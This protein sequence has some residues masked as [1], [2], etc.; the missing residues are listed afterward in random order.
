M[1]RLAQT[2]ASVAQATIDRLRTE[3]DELRKDERTLVEEGAK[4]DGWS[5][6]RVGLSEDGFGA[7]RAEVGTT[8]GQEAEPACQTVEGNADCTVAELSPATPTL[9]AGE[10]GDDAS[11]P[12]L[13]VQKAVKHVH[14]WE[15]PP[16]V[17]PDKNGRPVLGADG[18]PLIATA[19]MDDPR[20]PTGGSIG[21]GGVIL[22]ANSNPGLGADGKPFVSTDPR[23]PPGG[24]T[25]A[26]GV[27]LD[28]NGRAVLGAD[29]SISQGG[30]ILDA[31]GSPV[32]GSLAS[33]HE[34]M[35]AGRMVIVRGMQAKDL[36]DTD[37]K[38]SEKNICDPYLIVQLLDDEGLP[39][40]EGQTEYFSNVRKCAWKTTL[41]LFCDDQGRVNKRHIPP[42][43]AKFILM[44]W[45]KKKAHYLIGDITLELKGDKGTK[46]IEIPSRSASSCRPFIRFSY[47]ISPQMYFETREFMSYSGQ[48]EEL[49]DESAEP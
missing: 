33:K 29:G 46:T 32:L 47:E 16:G 12:V 40:S 28:A 9:Y 45:N 48:A 2:E 15:M 44:D 26:G 25:G 18:K 36:P 39:V 22:D 38:G 27:S 30:M 37:L 42:V 14:E 7:G 31:H 21:K 8:A 1:K 19:A 3:M 6:W 49:V 4:D 23:I 35:P 17:T 13:A 34:L 43:T 5:H 11:V 41:K 20:I 10:Q 24:S